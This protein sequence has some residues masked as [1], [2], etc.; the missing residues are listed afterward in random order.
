MYFIYPR[1]NLKFAAFLGFLASVCASSALHSPPHSDVANLMWIMTAVF[2]VPAVVLAW[3][4]LRWIWA[5]MRAVLRGP[6]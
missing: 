3:V 1:H 2:A 5:G 4:A 6:Q